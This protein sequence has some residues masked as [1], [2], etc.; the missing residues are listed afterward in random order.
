MILAALAFP[1]SA[2]TSGEAEETDNG[3][4]SEEQVE[5]TGAETAA[6]A[7]EASGEVAA[8]KICCGGGCDAPAGMCCND[9]GTCGGNHEELPT[10]TP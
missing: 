1:L 10:W 4:S 3:D 2:C 9:D 6:G 7:T 5:E 8:E